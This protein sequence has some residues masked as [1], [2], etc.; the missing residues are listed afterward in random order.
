MNARITKKSFERWKFFNKFTQNIF[1]NIEIAYPS[2]L[3]HII[4]LKN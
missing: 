4:I 3:K 2:N 1:D